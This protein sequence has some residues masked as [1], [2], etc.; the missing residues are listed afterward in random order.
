MTY[1][2]FRVSGTHESILDFSDLVGVT[3]R[4]DDIQGFD[5][6]WEKVL[7]SIEEM[8]QDHI[9]ESLHKRMT[10]EPEQPKTIMAL[11]DQNTERK[12]LPHAIRN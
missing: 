8:P 11:Y 7:L 3:P 4:G 5:T 2:Y 9:L 6:R 12:D 10:R 1:E